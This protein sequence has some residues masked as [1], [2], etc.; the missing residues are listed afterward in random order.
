MKKSLVLL[1]AC[2]LTV[3]SGSVAWGLDHGIEPLAVS[4]GR[5]IL[6][7]PDGSIRAVRWEAGASL[8]STIPQLH[9]PLHRESPGPL[10]A[11]PDG[12]LL[13]PITWLFSGAAES[14]K[15]VSRAP[16]TGL[17][18]GIDIDSDSRREII[19]KPKITYTGYPAQVYESTADDTFTLAFDYS[20]LSE[21]RG[22]CGTGDADSD[23]LEE[24]ISLD[25]DHDPWRP[26]V[27][28]YEQ[29]NP[30][31]YPTSVT[32]RIV[33]H[34]IYYAS[35]PENAY[36]DD[37]DYDGA[38][39][40]ILAETDPG[41]FSVYECRGD[42]TYEEVFVMEFY[43]YLLQHM[44]VT[45]DLT[46]NGLRE[47]LVGGVP[48]LALYEAVG[49]DSYAPIWYASPD[50][51]ISGM[52][53][54][55]DSDGDGRKEFLVASIDSVIP[56]TYM[57]CT[58]YEY[59]G[60]GG[61]DVTWEISMI[62]NPFDDSTAVEAVDLDGDGR[63]ELICNYREGS[64]YF[65]DIYKAVGDDTYE[66]VFSSSGE[67]GAGLGL[68]GPIGVGDFDRDSKV[69]IGL[70]ESLGGENLATAV[71]E[72]SSAIT[73]PVLHLTALYQ[74]SRMTLSFTIGAPEPDPVTWYT[75]LLLV[76][77][78]G[79]PFFPISIQSLDPLSPCVD[80]SV[81]FPL[82]SLGWVVAVSALITDQGVQ[83]LD[84]YVVD[85]G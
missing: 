60:A 17:A 25:F 15:M 2:I 14:H 7:G 4:N 54:V 80:T 26:I 18:P 58:L 43:D 75:G 83:A 48:Y 13:V 70:N 59:D 41:Y 5:T 1:V 72:T 68:G 10:P 73:D 84:Y 20:S 77:L 61:F 64:A 63:R 22:P 19:V 76:S 66:S 51:N 56:G 47:A 39:E 31:A 62:A 11:G 42:D 38:R 28:I 85:T 23:G 45:Q 9:P 12:P 50:R 21:I 74:S 53:Y 29:S 37:L 16:L 46:G 82:P 8:H 40:I 71:Y 69:E 79:S 65:L 24:I 34:H 49:D 44:I 52:A 33:G 36:I 67:A 81:A 27:N 78:P 30:Y 57:H 35:P 55:G 3:V 32:T 6:Q